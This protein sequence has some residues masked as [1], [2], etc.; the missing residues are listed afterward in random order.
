MGDAADYAFES[1]LNHHLAHVN[2]ECGQFGWCQECDEEEKPKRRAT[3][4]TPA[5]ERVMEPDHDAI[6]ANLRE[7][8]KLINL[9]LGGGCCI[10]HDSARQQR[11]LEVL[12]MFTDDSFTELKAAD[13]AD[14]MNGGG[15]AKKS[16]V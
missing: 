9:E 16:D 1:G 8:A 3:K 14:E 15:D 7:L 13:L 6:V 2:G 4:L 11:M 5:Q 12:A 10:E